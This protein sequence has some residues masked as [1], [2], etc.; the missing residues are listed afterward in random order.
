MLS[1]LLLLTTKVNV[2]PCSSTN[3]ERNSEGVGVTKLKNQLNAMMSFA[4]IIQLL[5][6]LAF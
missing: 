5:V 6:L 1:F 3:Y 2:L 4:I